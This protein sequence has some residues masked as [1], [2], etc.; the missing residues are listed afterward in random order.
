[1]GRH[2]DPLT[3]HRIGH[4]HDKGHHYAY[5]QREESKEG[6]IG[7]RKK[8]LLGSLDDNLV[9][10][11]ND[12]FRLMAVEERRMLIFP[13]EWDL[14]LV[15]AMD[16]EYDYK[17]HRL[18]KEY[19]HKD[20]ESMHDS[21]TRTDDTSI[22]NDSPAT[23]AYPSNQYRDQYNNQLYGDIWLFEEIL[24]SKGVVK[25]LLSV[26][27]GDISKTNDILT[28]A[29]YPCLTGDQAY[30][31]L[32]RWQD[33]S[34]T[35][36]DRPLRSDYITRLMQSITEDDR[37]K[38]LTSR[39]TDQPSGA[40]APCDSTTV[41]SYGRCLADIRWGN[42]KDRDDLPCIAEVVVY[43][44]ATHEPVYYK[45]FPGFTSDIS[46][47]RTI[48]RELTEFGFSNLIV[49]TDRGYCSNENIGYFVH[50]GIPFITC[51]K[52]NQSPVIDA[53]QNV[54]YDKYGLP[55]DMER[56][57][58]SGLY[59]KQF[60]AD[61]YEI[62]L[63]DGT[64]VLAENLVINVYLNIK[65]RITRLDD[66]RKKLESEDK[67]AREYQSSGELTSAR[68]PTLRRELP[69]YRINVDKKEKTVLIERNE[70]KIEKEVAGFGFFS[71]IMYMQGEKTAI[72]AYHDYK[73]R[74]EQEKYFYSMKDLADG[75]TAMSY[76]EE[77]R[78]GRDFVS[79]I[80][81]IALSWVRYRWA[82]T[83][84]RR[85][86]RSAEDVLDAM[87]PIRYSVYSDGTEHITT[88]TTE[89]ISI[90]DYLDVTPPM[91]ALSVI[92]QRKWQQAHAPKKRGPKSKTKTT[93]E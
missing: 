31:R 50:K 81:L 88:F 76:T 15:Q 52:V 82:T 80:G 87:R 33:I 75:D 60:K 57:E 27:N 44:L 26:F 62:K 85:L 28:L 90:C 24:E 32:A 22:P 9:F 86:F 12:K 48:V 45:S 92:N 1:M 7:K 84:L 42:N 4:H 66:Y 91:E 46:T 21:N 54:T 19:E 65:T 11:P 3:P 2:R 51:S 25:S 43:C 6:V 67:L 37:A 63:S 39:I 55:L 77:G 93:E 41:S 5:I 72:E 64:T 29:M 35:P 89:Q 59:C 40:L 83:E 73:L 20:D 16:A 58:E 34:H 53:L 17:E 13:P 47:I 69:H 78:R 74:D 18:K 68:V 56:D 49:I 36:S 61:P 14:H 70:S 79:F 71:S 23:K 8:V 30:Y 38:L 10:I